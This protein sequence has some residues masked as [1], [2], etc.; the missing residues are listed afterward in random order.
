MTQ[1]RVTGR[2]TLDQLALL[3]GLAV[4]WQ[5]LSLWVGEFALPS[6]AATAIK[7]LELVFGPT[8]WGHALATLQALALALSIAVLGGVGLGAWLG[9]SRMAGAVA[10]PL[11]TALYALPKVTLYPMI[12]L[13][14]GIGLSAKVCFGAIHGIMPITIFVMSGVR[15]I[16]PVLLKSGASLRLSPMATFLHILVPAA[17]PE[18]LSGL[19]VGLSLTLLGTLIGEMFAAREGLGF[20]LMQGISLIDGETILAIT[21]ILFIVAAGLN[22]TLYHLEM[23]IRGHLASEE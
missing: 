4:L 9:A 15:N 8:F 10:E 22:L 7:A 13:I 19:R 18:V 12:L 23:R 21:L 17:M 3:A 11:L 2:R 16:P 20:L 6:P 5:L 1:R 14:F